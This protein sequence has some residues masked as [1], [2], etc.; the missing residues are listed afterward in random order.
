LAGEYPLTGTPP[1]RI[2]P[3]KREEEAAQREL[4][5]INKFKRY[6]SSAIEKNRRF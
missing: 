6:I 5:G 3:A 2:Y 4:K 1:R